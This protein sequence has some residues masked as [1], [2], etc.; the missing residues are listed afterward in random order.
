MALLRGGRSGALT[1]RAGAWI[2]S[3]TP[4]PPPSTCQN[5]L[6]EPPPS[7]PVCPLP[8]P[9][10]CPASPAQ[11]LALPTR[12]LQ[13]DASSLPQALPLLPPKTLIHVAPGLPGCAPSVGWAE[14]DRNINLL[15]VPIA[16]PSLF[17]PT[18]TDVQTLGD[19][20]NV[21]LTFSQPPNSLIHSFVHPFVQCPIL[22]CRPHAGPWGSRW[23]PDAPSVIPLRA[24]PMTGE[25][26]TL[27]RTSGKAFR[28]GACSPGRVG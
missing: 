11:Q 15:R 1:P 28:G 13:G 25:Q 12:L 2:S 6:G 8:S 16:H 24:G 20:S 7:P 5:S 23:E 26:L 14:G 3:G 9:G 18:R 27:E 21:P 19:A 4:A 22:L 10:L 17:P